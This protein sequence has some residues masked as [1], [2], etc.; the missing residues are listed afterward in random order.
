NRKFVSILNCIY[1]LFFSIILF[2]FYCP[3]QHGKVD[4][5]GLCKCFILLKTNIAKQVQN[6]IIKCT[7]Q[8]NKD[9]AYSAVKPWLN[10]FFFFKFAGNI[11]VSP[12]ISETMNR[13]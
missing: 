3:Y 4:W 6:K 5:L 11:A 12:L 1:F 9:S 8:V 7:F 10:I 13:N 2:L